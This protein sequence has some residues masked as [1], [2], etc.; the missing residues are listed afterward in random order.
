[1]SQVE[2]LHSKRRTTSLLADTRQSEADRLEI[3][4]RR[5]D[6][7]IATFAMKLPS[8][9][10]QSVARPALMPERHNTFV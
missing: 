9:R 5:T 3:F 10:A 6:V 1:L 8:V 2:C 7:A 4:L